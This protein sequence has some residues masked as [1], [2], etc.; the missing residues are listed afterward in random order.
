MK[1]SEDDKIL[2]PVD[3]SVATTTTDGGDYSNTYQLTRQVVHEFNSPMVQDYVS[4]AEAQRQVAEQAAMDQQAAFK[5]EQAK[6]QSEGKAAESSFA[7]GMAESLQSRKSELQPAHGEQPKPE[8]QPAHIPAGVKE[9]VSKETQGIEQP[10]IDPTQAAAAGMG[11]SFAMSR[12]AGMA[13]MP[14]LSRAVAAGVVNAATDPLYG[15][16]AEVVGASHPALALPFNIAVGLLGGMTLEPAIE[17]GIVKA[18]AK[19]GKVLDPAQIAEQVQAMKGILANEVGAVGEIKPKSI[20]AFHWSKSKIVGDF[21]LNRLGKTTAINNPDAVESAKLG[22]WFTENDKPI[23]EGLKEAN[24]AE[25]AINNPLI[26]KNN[27][28][29]PVDVMGDKIKDAKQWL[30]DE[31]EKAG[32]GKK[33]RKEL[34]SKGYDGIILEDSEFDNAKSYIVFDKGQ[35]N[36]KSSGV[37]DD[38]TKA[39]VIEEVNSEIK[40]LSVSDI[41]KSQKGELVVRQGEEATPPVKV[42][43]GGTTSGIP[44]PPDMEKAGKEILAQPKPDITTEYAGDVNLRLWGKNLDPKYPEEFMGTL[45]SGQNVFK[46]QSEEARR[47]VQTN[48][49]SEQKAAAYHLEDYLGRK[50]GQAFNK[51]QIFNAQDNFINITAN[52]KAESA[53]FVKMGMNDIDKIEYMKALNLFYAGMMQMNGITAEAARAFGALKRLKTLGNMKFGELQEFMK[54]ISNLPPEKIAE[55]ISAADT[56]AEIAGLIRATK[57]ATTW[58]MFKELW[59]NLLIGPYSQIANFA[60]NSVSSLWMTG[61]H[62]VASIISQTPLIGSKEIRLG[63]SVAAAYGWVEGWKDG[64]KLFGRAW[65]TGTSQFGESTAQKVETGHFEPSITAEN[66]RGKLVGEEGN[67]NWAQELIN[68]NAPGILEEGGPYAVAADAMGEFVRAG[69]G[70]GGTRTLT[71]CDDLFKSIAYRSQLRALS[72]R[73][74]STEINTLD[75]AEKYLKSIGVDTSG[76]GEKDIVTKAIGNRQAEILTDPVTHAPE[77]SMEA[78]KAADYATFTNDLN[79]VGQTASRLLQDAPPLQLII[80]FFKTPWNVNKW[81][82]Q[83]APL[84]GQFFPSFWQDMAAGGAKRDLAIARVGMGTALAGVTAYLANDGYITGGGPTAKD[85]KL[86]SSLYNTNWKPYSITFDGVTYHPY[87]YGFEPLSTMVG[88]TADAV[89]IMKS[90]RSDDPEVQNSIESIAAAVALGWSKN[91]LNTTFLSGLTRFIEAVDD[92]DR[93]G[94]PWVQGFAGSFMPGALRDIEKLWSPERKDVQNL[95][96]MYKSKIPGFSEDLPRVRNRWGDVIKVDNRFMSNET[97]TSPVDNELI[98]IRGDLPKPK[99]DQIFEIAGK[100]MERP[101]ELTPH[102]YEDLIITMNKVEL[103]STGDNVKKTLQD[104]IKSPEYKDKTPEEQIYKLRGYWNEA[105]RLGKKEILEKYPDILQRAE[106]DIAA[107]MASRQ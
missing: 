98:R 59:V 101:V 67:R 44:Q 93:Y 94:K 74:A 79:P 15:T 69:F 103:Q 58:N 65:K 57:Q 41:L 5:K 95:M 24:P 7:A 75:S 14:S 56:P 53:R 9:E 66:I 50:L 91:S 13:L 107:Q 19:A 90:T 6:K 47:F 89:D 28:V 11:A 105:L 51:E 63:E 73:K 36:F 22:A 81:A 27:S 32:G 26:L 48:K 104:I 99:R 77:L 23:A 4:A 35:I 12:A 16:A 71:A 17:R 54:G 82:M 2:A 40:K 45:V 1:W 72:L 3:E 85:K 18:A 46:A 80:P 34:Q 42:K 37:V 62:G 38:L 88:W 8:L 78:A 30:M 43:G 49:M 21:D 83:R 102:Q 86:R 96:D 39:S 92:P 64:L 31:V 33:L 25:L 55:A 70:F 84:I 100:R 106:S 10:M 68:K 20:P 76:M 52:F 61:E 29:P 60:G 97:Q 87:K